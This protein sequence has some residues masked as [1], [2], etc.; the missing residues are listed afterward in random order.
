MAARTL[1]KHGSSTTLVG[2]Q[3]GPLACELPP[4]RHELPHSACCGPE[5]QSGCNGTAASKAQQTTAA[6][7]VKL[8]KKCA[9]HTGE[10]AHKKQG[11]D[12]QAACQELQ[13]QPSLPL[14]LPTPL[15]HFMSLQVLLNSFEDALQWLCPRDG[16]SHVW[17][18]VLE[19]YWIISSPC[20]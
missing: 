10:A 13:S 20:K 3:R 5:L 8:K 1:G 15:H 14:P 18:M 9:V 2:A 12:P 16:P 7:P 19:D 6:P 17:G 4:A 11:H